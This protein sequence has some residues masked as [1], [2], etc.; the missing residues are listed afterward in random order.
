M[1]LRTTNLAFNRSNRLLSSTPRGFRQGAF[2]QLVPLTGAVSPTASAPAPNLPPLG[3]TAPPLSTPGFLDSP[4]APGIPGAGV[5]VDQGLGGREANIG[6]GFQQ[7]QQTLLGQLQGFGEAERSRIDREFEAAGNTAQARL[8]ARG[9][10]GS[11]LS[12]NLAQGTERNRQE[13]IGQLNDRLTAQRLGIIGNIGGQQLGFQTGTFGQLLDQGSRRE[14]ANIS[15]QGALQRLLLQQQLAQQGQVFNSLLNPVFQ[16]VAD[17]TRD[18]RFF[19]E[20]TA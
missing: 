3:G 6:A 10:G 9:L 4:T 17:P 14:L 7:L 2:G 5:G 16:P 13:A 11:T 15:N 18:P 8:A 19:P 12:A 1:P 20:F